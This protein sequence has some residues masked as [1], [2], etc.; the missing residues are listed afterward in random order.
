MR[1]PSISNT[2]NTRKPDDTTTFSESWHCSQCPRP[3]TTCGSTAR[4]TRS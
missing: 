3:G 1:I 2:R 4:T